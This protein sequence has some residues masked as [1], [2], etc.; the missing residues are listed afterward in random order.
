MAERSIQATALRV[1]I[2]ADGVAVVFYDVPGEAVNTLRDSFA[3]DFEQAFG[4]IEADPAVKAI[5]IA[6]AK[7]DSFVV[8]ADVEMLARV[9]T[10]AEATALARGVRR[11]AE[12]EEREGG[13]LEENPAG[14]LVLFRQARKALLAKTHGH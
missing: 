3:E 7:P 13:A 4:K 8:G 11:M 14:R 6:S 2:G 10:Q 12:R 9:K 5:V 1:D